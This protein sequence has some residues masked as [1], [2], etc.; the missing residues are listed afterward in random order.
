SEVQIAMAVFEALT[1][2]NI[3]CKVVSVLCFELF[4]QQNEQYQQEI[5]LSKQ[6]QVLRVAIEACSS[7]GWHQFIGI[8]GIFVGIDSFGAS[9]KAS[10]LFKHFKITAEHTLQQILAKL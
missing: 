6:P 5:L 1:K 8:D 3:A 10:D 4:K 9:A 7:F 2:Q